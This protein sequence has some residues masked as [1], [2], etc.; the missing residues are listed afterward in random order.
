V[1]EGTENARK[2]DTYPWGSYSGY[3]IYDPGTQ[4]VYSTRRAAKA[5]GADLTALKRNFS[6]YLDKVPKG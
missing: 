1:L 3:E 4:Q 5:G 2:G 6:Y